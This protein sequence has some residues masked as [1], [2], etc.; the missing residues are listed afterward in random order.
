M[1]SLYRVFLIMLGR[2][3]LLTAIMPVA[4]YAKAW[5]A[6][7][8]GDRT[9]LFEGRLSLDFRKHTDTTGMLSTIL[10]G[11]GF[12]REMNLDVSHL[13]NMKRDITLISL[14]APAAY[15]AM[16]I[17]ISNIAGLIYS[18]SYSSFLLASIYYVLSKAA[19]SSL[20]FGVIAL[21]P[22]PPLDGFHIFY[23]FSWPKFRRWYFMNY[24]KITYW[25][26]I[27]LYGIF[28]LAI[29]S[30]GELSLIGFIADLWNMLFRHL[31]FFQPDLSKV[32][33][34]ILKV[35]FGFRTIFN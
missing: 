25:S 4:C 24:Q 18:I 12:G 19:Y 9:P 20:C 21:L 7:T 30:D 5:T 23:Q 31:L 28:A 34:K 13:K 22:L 16:Y 14:S 29:I 1:D 15:F 3:V 2:A 27:I 6:K 33:I 26:R 11:Y 35:V 8:L 10:L 32:P 17:I